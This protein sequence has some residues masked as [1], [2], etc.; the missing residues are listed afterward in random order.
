MYSDNTGRLNHRQYA[1]VPLGAALGAPF[2]LCLFRTLNEARPETHESVSSR[3]EVRLRTELLSDRY[4]IS[5]LS[6]QEKRAGTPV[7]AGADGIGLAETR[8]DSGSSS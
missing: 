4:R 5:T 2:S 3:I 6:T 1:T 8:Y 7:L